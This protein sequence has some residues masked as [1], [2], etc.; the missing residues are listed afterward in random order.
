MVPIVALFNHIHSKIV[1]VCA[2][3]IKVKSVRAAW[4]L[5]LT[6]LVLANHILINRVLTVVENFITCM[7]EA[8][9]GNWKM[10]NNVVVMNYSL[11]CSFRI[12]AKYV[13]CKCLISSARGSVRVEYD[14]VVCLYLLLNIK[15]GKCWHGSSKTVSCHN[16][17]G[18]WMFIQVSIHSCYNLRWKAVISVIESTMHLSIFGSIRIR[19]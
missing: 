8:H 13:V 4:I 3:I 16:D 15:S 2:R 1:Q 9:F 14:T 17:C 19:L 10:G 7:I 5:R 12:Q 18:I 6:R 11:V